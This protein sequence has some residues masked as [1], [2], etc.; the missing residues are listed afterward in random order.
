MSFGVFVKI[1]NNPDVAIVIPVY[2]EE[3]LVCELISRVLELKLDDGIGKEVIDAAVHIVICIWLKAAS[4]S[5][6]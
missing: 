3:R 1:E 5:P 2:N 6:E 4:S